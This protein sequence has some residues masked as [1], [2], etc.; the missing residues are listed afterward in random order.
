MVLQRD[1]TTA[2]YG[3]VVGDG[4]KDV[5]VSVTM[6]NDATGA[7]YTVPATIIAGPTY[8]LQSAANYTATWKAY[9]RP[10]PAGGS[11]TISAKCS[12]AGCGGALPVSTLERVTMGDVYFCSGQVRIGPHCS[13]RAAS[14]CELSI[15]LIG[16]M[17]ALFAVQYG[18]GN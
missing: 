15:D 5:S 3:Q 6:S 7:V 11:Y 16:G 13:P 10:A 1:A 2:V 17:A 4:G 9:L 18:T 14:F 12:G 8:S